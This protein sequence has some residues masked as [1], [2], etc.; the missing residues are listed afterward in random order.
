MF[1]DIIQDIF[2]C[3]GMN[4]I[5]KE[6]LKINEIAKMIKQIVSFKKYEAIFSPV[7]SILY[8][9]WF[10]DSIISFLLIKKSCFSGKLLSISLKYSSS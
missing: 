1:I 4:D 2:Y 5:A 7:L 9:K 10:T 8:F 3:F 6:Q